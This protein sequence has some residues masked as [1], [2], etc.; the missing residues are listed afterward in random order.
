MNFTSA[1]LVVEEI[2]RVDPST[3]ILGDIHNTLTNNALMMWGSEP[4]KEQWLPR[5][6]TDTVS[7]FCLS[8]AGS[9]SDAFA[10]RTTATESADGSYFTLNGSKLWISNALEAGVFLV[11]A[12]TDQSMGYK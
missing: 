4:L 10:M 5:L 9:G 11:F 2:S 6:A 7:S 8:E 1:C 3:S 12:N